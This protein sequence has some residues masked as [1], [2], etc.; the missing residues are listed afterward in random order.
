MDGSMRRYD[1]VPAEPTTPD[2]RMREKIP[3][4]SRFARTGEGPWKLVSAFGGRPGSHHRTVLDT[5]TVDGQKSGATV[6]LVDDMVA[7]SDSRLVC[8]PFPTHAP[9][10][11]ASPTGSLQSPPVS[12]GMVTDTRQCDGS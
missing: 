3:A 5:F 1:F 2:Q 11:L 9:E 4:R 8:S 12:V 10:I 7:V 6:P